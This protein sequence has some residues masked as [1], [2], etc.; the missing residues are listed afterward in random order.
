VR[1]N[2]TR[3]DR[4][5]RRTL[6]GIAVL[7][8]LGGSVSAAAIAVAHTV[9]TLP[10]A[11]DARLDRLVDLQ[12]ADTNSDSDDARQIELASLMADDGAAGPASDAASP[13]VDID[14]A[15]VD[16]PRA[17]R[18]PAAAPARSLNADRPVP[19]AKPK[20]AVAKPVPLPPKPKVT[21]LSDAQIAALKARLRLSPDQE[22]YWP[23]IETSLRAVVRQIDRANRRAHGAQAPVDTSTPEVERLKSAAMPLLMQMRSDQKAEIVTLAHIMGMEKMVAM[24]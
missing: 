15:P 13:M 21:V 24:L 12:A 6:F 10:S 23:E 19:V 17:D 1:P 2:Q 20:V 9:T 3:A 11:H 22:P 8:G 18:L 7:T 16:T 14:T 5:L 4:T